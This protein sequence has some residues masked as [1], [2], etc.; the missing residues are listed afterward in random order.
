MENFS[1]A[2]S[3]ICNT[4]DSVSIPS[5]PVYAR[6]YVVGYPARNLHW[7]YIKTENYHAIAILH[8]PSATLANWLVDSYSYGTWHTYA[9][10]NDIN[11][12]RATYLIVE[13]AFG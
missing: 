4:H 5:D 8:V 11:V 6:V 9:A 7:V 12:L 3:S 1:V 13:S 10:C 2:A